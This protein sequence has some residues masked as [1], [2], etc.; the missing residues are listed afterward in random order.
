MRYTPDYSGTG[1]IMN[2]PEMVEVMRA[3]AELGNGFAESISPERT[4]DYKGSFEVTADSGGGIR[5]DRAEAQIVNSSD[6]A[7]NVEWQ[8]GYKV[9]TRT[10]GA[11]E[12]L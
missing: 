6:H 3:K 12:T 9:L 11:L 10:L 8:D 1:Q 5:G 4:G 2:S 7:V